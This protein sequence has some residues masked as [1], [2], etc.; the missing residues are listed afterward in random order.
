MSDKELKLQEAKK[1]FE[2]ATKAVDTMRHQM[3]LRDQH[4]NTSSEFKVLSRELETARTVIG[5]I[6]D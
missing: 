5:D 4:P 1:R 6:N 2:R 3:V